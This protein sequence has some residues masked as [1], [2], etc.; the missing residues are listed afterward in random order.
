M[1]FLPSKALLSCDDSAKI[2]TKLKTKVNF[3]VKSKKIIKLGFEID[4]KPKSLVA[5]DSEQ[6]LDYFDLNDYKQSVKK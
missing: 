1:S 6:I 4:K 3:P 2:F 5:N